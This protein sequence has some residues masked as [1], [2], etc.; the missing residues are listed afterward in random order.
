MFEP[1]TAPLP[2]ET[3]ASSFSVTRPVAGAAPAPL[4]FANPHAGRVYPAEMMAA[5]ALDAATIRCSE[6]AYVDALIAS[7]PARGAVVVAAALARAYIDVNREP[8]ELD[9]AMYEDE[10]PLFARAR[11][12]R[13]AAGLGSIARVVSEGKEIYSRKLRFSEAAHRVEVGH[14]PYH[15]ALTEALSDVRRDHGL[16]VLID[17]HSMPAAAARA[18]L[19]GR[20]RCD[21]V[22][23]DRFGGSCA[24]AVTRLVEREL[25]AMGYVV[26]RNAPYAGGY[27]TEHYGRPASGV[28]ALQ[29]EIN[30]ALYL[31]EATLQPTQGFEPLKGDLDRLFGALAAVDWRRLV[32]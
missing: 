15:Q 26:V 19:L 31:D 32:G 6:D 3:Q 30:R 17:W 20:D 25:E 18:G 24:G 1:E 28:H 12:A 4:V 22:L 14:Q 2:A 21:F 10:L 11:T 27:T 5:S 7:A 23:G 29:I 9:P 13:V 16:A 8:W